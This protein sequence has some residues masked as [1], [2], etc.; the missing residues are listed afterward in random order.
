M[1]HKRGQATDGERS[2]S[3]SVCLITKDTSHLRRLRASGIDSNKFKRRRSD[4]N[5]EHVGLQGAAPSKQ[6]ERASRLK[7]LG[8]T[9]IFRVTLQREDRTPE[10][11][12]ADVRTCGSRALLLTRK[13]EEREKTVEVGARRYTDTRSLLYNYNDILLLHHDMP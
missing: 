2:T 6:N 11:G 8:E 4:T 10:A 5:I 1:E 7:A 3:A 9:R 12:R 13:G